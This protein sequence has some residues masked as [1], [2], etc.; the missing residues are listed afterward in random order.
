MTRDL[1]KIR[2][3]PPSAFY[4]VSNN[5]ILETPCLRGNEQPDKDI[6]RTDV[7]FTELIFL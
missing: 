5:I 6:L 1:L 2:K 7:L 3:G 4:A